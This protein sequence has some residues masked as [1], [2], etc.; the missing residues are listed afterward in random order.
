MAPHPEHDAGK[1]YQAADAFRAN[2]LL[3]D[4][5]SAFDGAPVVRPFG[6]QTFWTASAGPPW[7]PR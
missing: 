7:P 4:V 2:Y 5:S 1:I 3:R 6:G